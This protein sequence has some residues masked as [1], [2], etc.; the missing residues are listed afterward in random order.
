[1]ISVP[2]VFL[3]FRSRYTRARALL[4]SD[5]TEACELY[6]AH[7]YAC[8]WFW[9]G[10]ILKHLL[11]ADASYLP[12][13]GVH[14]GAPGRPRSAWVTTRQPLAMSWPEAADEARPRRLQGS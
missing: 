12:L 3:L 7:I 2:F 6:D 14:C 1:M 11:A 5:V 9:S 13:Y 10:H 4:P 8:T